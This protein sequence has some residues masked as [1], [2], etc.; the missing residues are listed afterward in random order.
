MQARQA[1][2]AVAEA[3]SAAADRLISPWW[4]HPV[5]GL[6]VAVFML[7][8]TTGGVAVQIAVG[9]AYFAGLGLLVSLYKARTGMWINGLTAGRASW[10]T[11][12]L[13]LIMVLAMGVS[14]YFHAVHGL[15]WPAWLAAAVVFVATNVLG[16]RFD[17]S[18]RRQLRNAS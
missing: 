7:A 8:F 16:S 14:Y 18:L 15:H 6:L 12:P 1:L 3:R 5:L 17:A 4:Y 2:D 10:W 13:M 11:V 9:L